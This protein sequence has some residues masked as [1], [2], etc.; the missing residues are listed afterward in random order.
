VL[1]VYWAIQRPRLTT[2]L[3]LGLSAGL[4]L[5]WSNDFALP[6]AFGCGLAAL[7]CLS[8]I[9]SSGFWL[10]GAA[11]FLLGFLLGLIPLLL[12]TA[13]HLPALLAFNF[14]DVA[15]DQWWYYGPWNEE[16]RIFGAADLHRL[17]TLETLLALVALVLVFGCA[18]ARRDPALLALSWLGLVLLLG[19]ALAS[20]G[21]HLGGY[22][23][24]L[25]FWAWLSLAGAL[26]SLAVRLTRGNAVMRVIAL[27]ALLAGSIATAFAAQTRAV[28]VRGQ[29]Q[30]DEQHFW[31]PELGGYLNRDWES[32]I[33]FIRQT[34]SDD[35]VFEEYWGIWSAMRRPQPLMPVDSV[36]HALGGLRELGRQMLETRPEWV[37][38]SFPHGW[39]TWSLSA[40][41]WLYQALMED[42]QPVMTSPATVIWQHQPRGLTW[43]D[44]D[45]SISTR[46]DAV[47]IDALQRGYYEMRLRHRPIA[48]GRRITLLRSDVVDAF[49]GWAVLQPGTT[50]TLLPGFAP[51][52]GQHQHPGIVL[53]L[54]DGDRLELT[55]CSARQMS[56]Q[57][58]RLFASASAAYPVNDAAWANGMARDL[59]AMRVLE[60]LENARSLVPGAIL[61]L[62]NGLVLPIIRVRRAP[63]WLELHFAGEPVD[64]SVLSEPIGYQLEPGPVSQGDP[65][66]AV[67]PGERRPF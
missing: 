6:T 56:G 23:P 39:Q 41:Y 19:G 36:I 57:D 61:R 27:G 46:G 31:I 67:S 64:V 51:G 63:P 1:V 4:A 62:D 38:T 25:H 7:H 16:A 45:C 53:P 66:H 48:E 10:R 21:G 20:I 58:P 44:L 60:T 26:L 30:A 9:R 22:F 14:I 3:V 50:E 49:H 15:G 47:Y 18:L 42:Y 54:R 8:R 32:Y 5:I 29:A 65:R 35:D 12:A 43:R 34:P 55:G 17:L 40:N 33:R 11:L 13:G 2:L 28:E 52:A 37:V 59:S 24:P